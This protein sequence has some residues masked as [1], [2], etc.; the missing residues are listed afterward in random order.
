MT[1]SRDSGDQTDQTFRDRKV[2]LLRQMSVSHW[3]GAA[4]GLAM[5]TDEW[6]NRKNT[7][8]PRAKVNVLCVL[9]YEQWYS[10]PIFEFETLWK[11]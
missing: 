1:S 4:T 9:C 3:I 6:R 8:I 11:E 10:D 7:T 2:S 5:T